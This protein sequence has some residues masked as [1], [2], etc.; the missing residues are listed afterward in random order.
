LSVVRDYLFIIFVA[1]LLI[2]RP[3]LQLQP[4]DTSWR[5]D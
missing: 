4:E 2:S 5:G 3:Y 1:T